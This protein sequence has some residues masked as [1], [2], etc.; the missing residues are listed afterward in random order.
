MEPLR[1]TPSTLAPGPSP[2]LSPL[3]HS[4]SVWLSQD[5]EERRCYYQRL[6]KKIGMSAKRREAALWFS[7]SK[8]GPPRRSP[9]LAQPSQR[10][11]YI[12]NGEEA[13]S[14]RGANPAYIPVEQPTTFDLAVNLKTAK[15]LGLTISRIIARARR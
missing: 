7:I 6:T 9:P 1:T 8:F 12:S 15:A 14:V 5:A 11:T 3:F 10:L 13:E 2:F 4:G